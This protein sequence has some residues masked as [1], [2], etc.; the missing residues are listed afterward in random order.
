MKEIWK[1][2]PGYE[3]YYQV[4]NIGNVRSMDRWIKRSGGVGDLHVKEKILAN[5]TSRHG[6]V[7]LSLHKDK[8]SK[9]IFAH[10]LVMLAFVGEKTKGNDVNHINGIKN[11]NRLENLEYCTR[12][13]NMIHAFNNGLCKKTRKTSKSG[14]NSKKCVVLN[15]E[16]GIFH[17]SVVETAKAYNVYLGSME[18][19]LSGTRKLR[20]PL[21][22]VGLTVQGE[23]I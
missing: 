1:D 12:S 7:Q 2:I 5:C 9:K 18:K 8:K 21:I 15:T 11:D 19:M 23:F 16:S 22:K 13:E 4:S 6:Y 3:G 17:E 14:Y 10:V 20:Y